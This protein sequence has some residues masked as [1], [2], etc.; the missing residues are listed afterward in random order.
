MAYFLH[1]HCKPFLLICF[2]LTG[3]SLSVRKRPLAPGTHYCTSPITSIVRRR[4]NESSEEGHGS[5]VGRG[6]HGD[7]RQKGITFYSTLTPP[8]ETTAA[9][10]TRGIEVTMVRGEGLNASCDHMLFRRPQH[11]RTSRAGLR[12]E[13]HTHG[14]GLAPCRTGRKEGAW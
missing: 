7:Q 6:L 4:L 11:L 14:F 10:Y 9:L 1:C 2:L 5:A 3:G 12:G 8:P 13:R